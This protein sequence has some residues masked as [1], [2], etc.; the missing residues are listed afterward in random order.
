MTALQDAG[1]AVLVLWATGLY[2]YANEQ[3]D[4]KIRIVIQVASVVVCMLGLLAVR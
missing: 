1:A 4:R 2:S 3:Q